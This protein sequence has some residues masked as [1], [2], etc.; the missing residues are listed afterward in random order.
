MPKSQRRKAKELETKSFSLIPDECFECG[1]KKFEVGKCVKC[2][3]NYRH[4][5]D[6]PKK[7]KY[8]VFLTGKEIEHLRKKDDK[9]KP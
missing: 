7:K 9:W 1:G 3:R 5:D 8:K 2:G 6:R 4:V